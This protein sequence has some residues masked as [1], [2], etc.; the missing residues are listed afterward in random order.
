M[1]LEDMLDKLAKYHEERKDDRLT[2]AKPR[3]WLAQHL[4]AASF[5][6]LDSKFDPKDDDIKAFQCYEKAKNAGVGAEEERVARSRMV[7]MSALLQEVRVL[8]MAS[9]DGSPRW[10]CDHARYACDTSSG[11]MGVFN[12]LKEQL[13]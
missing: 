11:C 4:E 8:Y 1:A 10:A 3:K 13:K 12:K 2:G 9:D 5:T 6:E 7:L